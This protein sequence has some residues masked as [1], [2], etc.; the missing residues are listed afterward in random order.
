MAKN[1]LTKVPSEYSAQQKFVYAAKDLFDDPNHAKLKS[2]KS[3]NSVGKALEGK[4]F[5]L[6]MVQGFRGVEGNRDVNLQ[7][8]RAQAVVVRNYLVNHF[9]IDDS[10]VK[11]KGNGETQSSEQDPDRIEIVVYG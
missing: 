9:K 7:L 8:S 4:Q 10:R 2:E 5:R 6:V 3:L 11:T 1:E